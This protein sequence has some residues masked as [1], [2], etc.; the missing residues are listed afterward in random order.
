MLVNINV[1]FNTYTEVS[2]LIRNPHLIN[3]KDI[4]GYSLAEFIK[5]CKRIILSMNAIDKIIQLKFVLFWSIQYSTTVRHV[6]LTTI[7]ILSLPI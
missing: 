3:R 5:K 6:D 7:P 2:L 1:H 4:G